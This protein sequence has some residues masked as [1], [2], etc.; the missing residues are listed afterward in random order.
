M[1]FN[2]RNSMSI[3]T[4]ALAVTVGCAWVTHNTSPSSGSGPVGAT[5]TIGANGAVVPKTVTIARGQV[6]QFVNKDSK[7]HSMFSDPHPV[8]TDCRPI[9]AVGKLMPG[10]SRNTGNFENLKTCGFHDHSDPQNASLHGTITIAQTA[11]QLSPF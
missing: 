6:V 9:N 2:S 1:C 3:I 5:V 11:A 8:H 4:I 10:E 7:D